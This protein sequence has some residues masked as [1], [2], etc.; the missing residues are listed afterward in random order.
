M[1]VRTSMY[2]CIYVL[3]K[4]DMY[5]Y[6]YLFMNVVCIYVSKYLC[7]YVCMYYVNTI[8]EQQMDTL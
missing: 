3:R 5:V 6:F 4:Y 2:V 7:M 8:L 1:Y